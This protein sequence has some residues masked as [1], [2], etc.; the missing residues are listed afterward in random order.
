MFSM[1]VS[2]LGCQGTRSV[3]LCSVRNLLVSDCR[4][5]GET[6]EEGD[7]KANEL[8]AELRVM[9]SGLQDT[10]SKLQVE[11]REILLE[12]LAE[13]DRR[14]SDI[15]ETDRGHYTTYFAT[16]SLSKLVLSCPLVSLRP[17][18]AV[19]PLL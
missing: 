4:T 16:V 8:L 2:S 7:Q 12:L 1:K 18:R 11:S 19:P 17:A 15:A 5:V 14:Y 6:Q 3:R 13:F 10:L 9:R